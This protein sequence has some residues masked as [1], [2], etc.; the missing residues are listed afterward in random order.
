MQPTSTAETRAVLTSE[1]EV[2]RHAY[3]ELHKLELLSHAAGGNRP[4]MIG[5]RETSLIGLICKKEFDRV[6]T[7]SLRLDRVPSSRLQ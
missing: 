7:A 1:W 5:T 3:E 6:E 4:G 2:V